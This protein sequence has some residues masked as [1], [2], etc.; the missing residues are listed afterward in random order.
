MR[1][2]SIG[3][4]F[5]SFGSVGVASMGALPRVAKLLL[6]RWRFLYTTYG[7]SI[8]ARLNHREEIS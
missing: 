5:R 8:Q 6:E 3:S 2:L 1:G 4:V 7:D